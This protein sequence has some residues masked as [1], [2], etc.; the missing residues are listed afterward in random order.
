MPLGSLFFELKFTLKRLEMW[1]LEQPVHCGLSAPQEC[2]VSS[3]A[4]PG[5]MLSLDTCNMATVPEGLNFKLYPIEF[6]GTQTAL[7]KQAASSD[8]AT[9]GG[10]RALDSAAGHPG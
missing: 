5:C 1:L 7:L 2:S 8:S 3:Q 6:T 10:S 4:A 9:L